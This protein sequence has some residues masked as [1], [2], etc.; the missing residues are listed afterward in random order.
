[1]RSLLAAGCKVRQSCG[2]VSARHTRHSAVGTPAGALSIFD[3]RL[4]AHGKRGR[5]RSGGTALRHRRREV[6]ARR[7]GDE[8]SAGHGGKHG[9]QWRL[10]RDPTKGLSKGTA[11]K[12][13]GVSVKSA[14]RASKTPRMEVKLPLP[15][16]VAIPVAVAAVIACVFGCWLLRRWQH[17][18]RINRIWQQHVLSV[19]SGGTINYAWP[20]GGATARFLDGRNEEP[21][22]PS[23]ASAPPTR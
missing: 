23:E 15:L 21:A 1:M 22:T 13:R 20:Q 5:T 9:S 2:I 19:T 12:R 6:E 18:R 8:Q 11:E 17:R 7:A 10:S 3:D 4:F 16:E 14:A